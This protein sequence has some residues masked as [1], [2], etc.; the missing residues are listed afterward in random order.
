MMQAVR[1]GEIIAPQPGE[2]AECPG[3][4]APVRA[5]CGSINVW[6]FA[7]LAA[8]D[9]DPWAEPESAWHRGW[10]S[11][12]PPERREV[13]RDH[14]R[15]DIVTPKGRVVELQHGSLP[16]DEALERETFYGDMVWLLD[17][18]EWATDDIDRV[19]RLTVNSRGDYCSFRWKHCW[20]WVLQL[21]RP[22]FIDRG[23]S[24]LQIRKIRGPESCAGW[25]Y[26]HVREAF[27]DFINEGAA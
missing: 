26:L 22:V 13:V 8:E 10:K 23:Y 7:H 2:M 1:S 25:G 11:R 6:H 12:V 5:K 27:I 15:A 4:T 18:T 17:G 24:I 3:C 9:C 14:H 19:G 20:R 21:R 16:V